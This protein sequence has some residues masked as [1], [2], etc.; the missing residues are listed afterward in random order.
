MLST[1]YHVSPS[2]VFLCYGDRG[3]TASTAEFLVGHDT[4]PWTHAHSLEECRD[5]TLYLS[6][7]AY[8][9]YISCIHVVS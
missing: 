3:E 6:V 7:L 4:S 9:K 2:Q 5:T 1:W 8:G